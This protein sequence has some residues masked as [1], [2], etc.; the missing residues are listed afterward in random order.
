[1]ILSISICRFFFG[2]SYRMTGFLIERAI[3]VV[4][5]CFA[6]EKALPKLLCQL[7][8][9]HSSASSSCVSNVW[10][11]NAQMKILFLQN[12]NKLMSLVRPS[13]PMESWYQSKMTRA[14]ILFSP[15]ETFWNEIAGVG[16][17]ASKIARN[18]SRYP[19]SSVRV[20]QHILQGVR[21]VLPPEKC[22]NA[23]FHA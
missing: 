21:I 1:M 20:P 7:C 23:F 2:D 14:N 6:E 11:W 8:L 3:E 12:E 22:G 9:Q 5:L 13:G 15:R 10:K 4:A 18:C 16:L 17:R 19:G